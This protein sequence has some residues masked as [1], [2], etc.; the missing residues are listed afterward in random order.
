[1]H[2]FAFGRDTCTRL[3]QRTHALVIV[4]I[5]FFQLCMSTQSDN[6]LTCAACAGGNSRMMYHSWKKATF[7]PN[8]RVEV[9]PMDVDRSLADMVSDACTL[10][11]SK[12]FWLVCVTTNGHSRMPPY[13]P[14]THLTPGNPS[15]QSSVASRLAD[16][17]KSRTQE[18]YVLFGHSMGAFVVCTQV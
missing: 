12:C 14:G 18:P 15:C 13:I 9:C 8:L 3:Y 4:Q 1:M 7:P 16:E 2:I 10:P 17:I 11:S 5:K 6:Q